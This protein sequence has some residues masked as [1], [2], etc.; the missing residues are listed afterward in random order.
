MNSK[1]EFRDEWCQVSTVEVAEMGEIKLIV[2]GGEVVLRWYP[3]LVEVRCGRGLTTCE[4]ALLCVR[5]EVDVDG[6]SSV[7]SWVRILGRSV[8]P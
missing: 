4:E 3:G 6:G 5:T 2:S 7:C 1:G 8:G